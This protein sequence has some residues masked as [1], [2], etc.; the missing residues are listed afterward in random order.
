MFGRLNLFLFT[1][2]L[3]SGLSLD[4]AAAEP[5]YTEFG[6][7]T[8]LETGWADGTMTVRLDAPFVNSGE[9]RVVPGSGQVPG[10]PGVAPGHPLTEIAPC[11]VTNCSASAPVRQIGRL[12]EGRISG[13]S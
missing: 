13:S 7:I 12:E 4:F 5:Q 1:A 10:I 11:E 9:A 3:V 2:V 6:Y 8:A